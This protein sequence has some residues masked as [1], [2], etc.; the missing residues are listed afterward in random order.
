MP[1]TNEVAQLVARWTPE[2]IFPAIPEA[3][4][5]SPPFAPFIAR[6]LWLAPRIV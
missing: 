3:E 4:P 5:A 1:G 2:R 6:K